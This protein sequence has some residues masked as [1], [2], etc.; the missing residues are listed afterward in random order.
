M[1]NS[2]EVFKKYIKLLDEVYASVSKTYI[3]DGLNGIARMGAN[4]GEILVPK[5]SMDGLA[6]YDRNTGYVDGDVTLEYETKKFNYDRGRAF[7]IDAMDNEETAGIAFGKLSSEFIRTKVVPEMDAVRF[8]TYASL[9]GV[10]KK[11]E[12]AALATGDA[13]L[14]AINAAVTALDEAMVPAERRVL[15]ITPTLNN[16]LLGLD[17]Y[18]S[19]AILDGF[20]AVIVVPQSIFYSQVT[21]YDGKTGGQEKGGFKVAGNA[22]NFMIVQKDAIMQYTK[23]T[24]NKIIT[25]A[26]NQTADAWKF[27]YRAYGLNEAYDNK[28]VGIYVNISNAVAPVSAPAGGAP[29]TTVPTTGSK[30]DK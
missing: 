14:G 5:M 8:A 4:A 24:V 11:N 15:F 27:F 19:K 18:K 20:E 29:V 2:I 22:I 30:E 17:T 23:H 28:Q 16:L 12:T 9:S 3:L 21:K 25:P 6:D 7:S 10:T 26:Q 13:V 1:A